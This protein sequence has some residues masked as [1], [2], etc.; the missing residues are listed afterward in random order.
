MLYFIRSTNLIHHRLDESYFVETTG[1]DTNLLYLF[2]RIRFFIKMTEVSNDKIFQAIVNFVKDLG[3]AFAS[4]N[5]AL[6]LY[7]RLIMKTTLVHKEAVEKHVNAFR[8][9]YLASKDA[10]VSKTPTFTINIFYS[11]KVY[12]NMND[13]FALDMDSDTRSAIWNHIYVISSL[14]DPT[15]KDLLPTHKAVVNPVEDMTSNLT[16]SEEDQLLSKV[17]NKVQQ[18]VTEDTTDPQQAISSILSSDLIP[19]LVG[20][21]NAGMSNGTFDLGKMISSVEKMVGSMGGQEGGGD[22]LKGMMSMLNQ[23]R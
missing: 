8:T 17:I 11:A 18:H 3:D 10:I 15:I 16:N 12:I 4:D 23:K 20:T 21:I 2:N 9:F 22:M 7:E 13:I 19:E 14:L 5:H 6:A 1:V